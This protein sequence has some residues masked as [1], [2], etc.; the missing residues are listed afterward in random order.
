[1]LHFISKNPATLS[2]QPLTKYR[3]TFKQAEAK[4]KK[5]GR[6]CTLDFEFEYAM[7]LVFRQ[8][9]FTIACIVNTDGMPIT[10]GY[11]KRNAAFDAENPAKSENIA[12]HRAISNCFVEEVKELDRPA[13]SLVL[14]PEQ[15]DKDIMDAARYLKPAFALEVNRI[16]PALTE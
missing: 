13:D 1:M 3:R 14:F 8:G 6:N 5:T 11:A 9:N 15:W 7:V 4:A 2:I 16:K 12:V 10:F